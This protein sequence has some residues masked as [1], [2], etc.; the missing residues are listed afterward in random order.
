MN[1]K[2]I[3]LNEV[4][5]DQSALFRQTL[6]E[7]IQLEWVPS[8]RPAWFH[9]EQAMVLQ[10]VSGLLENSRE[11]MPE[12]GMVR[13]VGE[14]VDVDEI[15]SRI[16]PAA[17]RGRFVRLTLEDSSRGFPKEKLDK[18]FKRLPAPD[19]VANEPL[20]LHLIAGIVRR[21]GGWIEAHSHTGGGVTFYVYFPASRAGA[22]PTSVP[23]INE[24]IL[25]V[26]DEPSIRQLVRVVLENASYDVVEAESGRRALSLW[27]QN[28]NRVK[29]LLTDLVMPDG[30]NGHKLAQQ[31]VAHDP[32]LR[33]IYTS[34]YELDAEA[35]YDTETGAAAF[36]HKPYDL[37]GLLAMVHVAMSNWV[38]SAR[39]SVNPF[40]A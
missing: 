25:L 31:L 23:W 2:V 1:C 14:N 9:A 17:R 24:T 12:G 26:D 6:G 11:F 35:R 27:E 16:Q 36:L 18:M 34:G 4:I 33:V 5:A 40:P 19:R 13:L 39:R 38:S 15:H 10:V 22:A 37:R 30:V 28:R 7:A 32:A 20:A 21:R 29:L 8:R 3:D